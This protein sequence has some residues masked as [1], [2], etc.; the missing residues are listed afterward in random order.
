MLYKRIAPLSARL[1][2]AGALFLSVEFALRAQETPPPAGPNL[3][4]D[5][6]GTDATPYVDNP[7]GGVV[8][9]VIT[10]PAGVQLAVNEDGQVVPTVFGP[11]CAV[12]DLN[13]DGLPDLVI[14]DPHGYFWYF[15]NSGTPTKPKFTSGEIM[16][17][18]LG[19][20]VASA[21][22]PTLVEQNYDAA[23][24]TVPRIQLVDYAGDK[25]LSIVAG[26]YEGKLFYIHNV[27]SATQPAFSMPQDLA[28]ITV[29]TYSRGF[30]WC[31]FLAPFL[32]DFTGNGQ[33]DLVMGEG[34]YA[35]NS[36]YR[37]VNRGNN[38]SPLFDENHTTKI[39]PGYG[40]E[41]LTPQVVDW[42]ND[43]KPDIIAGERKGFINLWLNTSPDNDPAHLQFGDTQNPQH[44]S[45][46][47]TE[48]LGLLTTVAVGDLTNNK[49]P[50][51][52]ISNSDDHVVYALN[53]GKLG[54]P[55]F[56]L[57]Q[58]IQGVNPFPKIFAAPP[59]WRIL[60]SF[61][62]PYVLLASTKLRDDPTFK[63]PDD[64]PGVRSALKIYTVP[65]EHTYFR[66]EV[67]PTEDT[68]I[69]AYN[70]NIQMDAGTHYDVSFWCKT[71]G[72]VENLRYFFAGREDLGAQGVAMDNGDTARYNFVENSIDGGSSW[73]QVKGDICIEK[74]NRDKDDKPTP[75]FYIAFGGNGGTVW[76]TDFHMTK[77]TDQ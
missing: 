65:H 22:D 42:N 21:D 15:P 30:L 34:T 4:A 1:L 57:P 2:V 19:E 37:L 39:I 52:V 27:G 58:P 12:G 17:I 29:S 24:N 61:S 25:R 3:M 47:G 77:K 6:N 66:N 62:M 53:K 40:R 55:A 18:W 68:H 16:P 33:L 7:W 36:I 9:G 41:H 14:A 46:G 28:S 10:M 50:N 32:Y 38:G 70:G 72:N 23:D 31:N 8:N 76:V 64:D 43:G 56:D 20:P 67:Y 74:A 48:Q 11:S 44:V 60:K 54:A 51:L 59:Q 45:F 71:S 26:N 49:L 13:G 35:S 73:A 75:G 5:L 69:I 63:A